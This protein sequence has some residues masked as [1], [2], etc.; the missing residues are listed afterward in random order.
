VLRRT[1]TSLILLGILAVIV[2]LVAIAWPGITILALV[3]LFAIYA[4]IDA[5]LQ[6]NRAFT[7]DH[8]GPVIGHLLLALLDLGAGVFAIAWPGPTALVLVLIFGIWA[9]FSGFF[10]IAQAFAAGERAGTRIL[11]LIGGFVSILFGIVVFAH[12]G[13]GAVT[14]ALLFGLF[15]LVYGFQR[16]SMGVEMHRAQ[17][18]LEAPAH[19]PAD[20]GHPA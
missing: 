2:G 12:P 6:V 17:R 19:H 18:E 13:I 7:S 16:I 11:F 8:A 4:F 20:H 3:I 15:S 9:F 10:E 14:L 1:S 5:G